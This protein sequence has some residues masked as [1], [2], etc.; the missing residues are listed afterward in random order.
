M[1]R[2]HRTAHLI[3]WLAAAGVIAVTLALAL[4][5]RAGAAA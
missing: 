3:M 5:A 2:R 4:L 1:T